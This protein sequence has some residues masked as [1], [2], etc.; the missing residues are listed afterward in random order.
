M[1]C[2]MITL[3]PRPQARS[4]TPMAA[5]VLPL[6]LP[7]LTMTNPLLI[8]GPFT[9]WG[10]FPGGPLQWSWDFTSTQL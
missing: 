3:S 8:R 5:V 4:N 6:P 2:S 1:N 9:D 7:V 10:L